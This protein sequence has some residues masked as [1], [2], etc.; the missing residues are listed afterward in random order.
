M[1]ETPTDPLR[2]MASEDSEASAGKSPARGPDWFVALASDLD[3]TAAM[4][5]AG[6]FSASGAGSCGIA[7]RAMKSLEGDAL[8]A[9]WS[10]MLDLLER[11]WENGHHTQAARMGEI[12]LLSFRLPDEMAGR[13]RSS[14]EAAR[15]AE[16]TL[17]VEALME[18]GDTSGAIAMAST[19]DGLESG[20]I[21]SLHVRERWLRR[22][23]RHTFVVLGA[24]GVVMLGLFLVNFYRAVLATMALTVPTLPPLPPTPAPVAELIQAVPRIVELPLEIQKACAI[25]RRVSESGN[26][27]LAN[28]SETNDPAAASRLDDF[29]SKARATCGNLSQSATRIE[30]LTR[31]VGPEEIDRMAAS[32]LSGH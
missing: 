22:S 25:A 24:I 2:S 18:E 29:D 4:V 26:R 12:A 15:I 6:E 28:E 7:F 3:R 10:Y 16:K 31:D 21:D 32:I 5:V 23:R 30:E 20:Y 13:I 9:G 17:R 8:S 19:V 14:V 27:M 11:M 1:D